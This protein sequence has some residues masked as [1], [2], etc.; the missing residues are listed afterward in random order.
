MG[1]EIR[2]VETSR[3][4]RDFLSLP[5]LLYGNSPDWSPPVFSEERRSADFRH[6]QKH[7]RYE[8]AYFLAYDIDGL[9]VGRI[10]LSYDRHL[11]EL[12]QENHGSWWM[13]ECADDPEAADALFHTAKR[14]FD[15][16][17]VISARGPLP[18]L[19]IP[20]GGIA[21]KSA[22]T[23]LP[24]PFKDSRASYAT[25][26]RNAG[27]KSGSCSAAIQ[28]DLES[29]LP[30]ALLS[31]GAKKNTENGQLIGLPLEETGRSAGRFV[32]FCQSI[33]QKSLL[34]GPD[35]ENQL[36]YFHRWM[37][38]N[39]A[40]V[41]AGNQEPLAFVIGVTDAHSVTRGVYSFLK[42]IPL[43]LKLPLFLSSRV[44]SLFQ[45]VA[46]GNRNIMRN[47]P[48]FLSKIRQKPSESAVF[49]FA[50]DSVP[51]KKVLLESLPFGSDRKDG[52]S[53]AW[54]VFSGLTPQTSEAL[55]VS[56]GDSRCVV[57]Q[58][59]LLDTD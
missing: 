21:E 32:R 45:S 20:V 40:F 57:F 44:H 47:L 2:K 23:P 8:K 52:A 13:F 35:M 30:D 49:L 31:L 3:Q 46:L 33:Y 34:S 9:P 12:E 29:P 58:E 22:Q 15:A 55:R 39:R 51:A 48:T 43:F 16:R 4:K 42:G 24:F 26:L 18:P 7:D 53:K 25:L 14:W 50:G 38:R 54:I 36:R 56:L 1:I 17:G 37:D 11:S 27:L 59:Y 19:G 10:A 28:I 41:A 5:Q 6:N